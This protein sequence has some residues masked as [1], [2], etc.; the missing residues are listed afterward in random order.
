V[1][2]RVAEVGRLTI[3]WLSPSRSASG[4]R[5]AGSGP[6]SIGARAGARRRTDFARR[7]LGL[8]V[9]QT[10][11][12][13]ALAHRRPVECGDGR[14]AVRLGCHRHEGIADRLAGGRIGRH[15]SLD[16]DAVRVEQVGE[17]LGID[18]ERH[19]AHEQAR[20]VALGGRGDLRHLVCPRTAT[21]ALARR[22]SWQSDPF[23]PA[24]LAGNAR[25]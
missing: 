21:D 19:V 22:S 1:K 12:D 3:G 16:H 10:H 25:P 2:L 4:R 8:D 17:F 7:L 15:L 14:L 9:G 6:P 13:L 24:R 23:V 20:V 5:W 11:F 18:A